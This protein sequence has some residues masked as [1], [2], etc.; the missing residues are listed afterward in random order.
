MF[1]QKTRLIDLFNAVFGKNLASGQP[2]VQKQ[3]KSPVYHESFKFF[4]YYG[5]VVLS[6]V[7]KQ[8]KMERVTLESQSYF[9]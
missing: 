9:P 4:T 6:Q 1:E 2:A 7:V 8:R 3:N 5:T